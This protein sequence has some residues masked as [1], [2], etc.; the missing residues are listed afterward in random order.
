M[1]E[2]LKPYA[3]GIRYS[4]VAAAAKAHGIP[5]M[6]LYQRFAIHDSF[7][8]NGILFSTSESLNKKSRESET[9]PSYTWKERFVQGGAP[10]GRKPAP[11]LGP[12]R[13]THS[14]SHVTPE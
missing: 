1:K 14:I 8:L 6:T 11:L 7:V 3:A 13:V 9:I 4:S 10:E 2:K 12:R 5:Y